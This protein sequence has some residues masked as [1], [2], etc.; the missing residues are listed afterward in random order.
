MKNKTSTAHRLSILLA[1]LFLLSATLVEPMRSHLQSSDDVT[2][3]PAQTFT[4]TNTNNSGAGSLTQAIT[5]ANANPGLDTINFNVPGSGIRFIFVN[6]TLPAITSPV[7]IDGT[8]QPG[9]AGTPLIHLEGMGTGQAL[10]ITAG[11]STIKGLSFT[12]FFAGAANGIVKISGTGNNI[13]TRCSFGVRGD[14]TRPTTA[15]IGILI[16]GS[17][18]NRV[19][20]TTAADRNYFAIGSE[21]NLV[22][23]NGASGNRVTGNW[24][25]TGPNGTRMDSFGRDAIRILNSPSNTIGGSVGTTPGGA[26]TGECNLIDGA[27]NNGIF[28][29][30]ST[31]TGNRII[32]NFVGLFANGT[33]VNQNNL[34]IRIDN[35]PGNTVGGSSAGERN[36]ITGNDGLAGIMVTGAAST[37]TVITGNYIGLFTNGTS[38]P[39]AASVSLDGVLVNAGAANTRI[40]GVMPGERNVVSG[41]R[42]NGIEIAGADTNLVQGNYIGTDASGMARSTT[43]GNGVGM[44]FANN[45]TI[46]GTAGT[47]LGGACTGACNVISG[48]GNDGA[49]DGI[50]VRS[51]N[52]NMIDGNYIGLNA[53]GT[54]AILN[55]RTTSGSI[56]NGNAISLY[57]ANNNVIGRHTGSFG[58]RPGD[59]DPTVPLVNICIQSPVTGNYIMFNDETGAYILENCVRGGG[60]RTGIGTVQL[61]LATLHFKTHMYDPIVAQA[62]YNVVSNRGSGHATGGGF[63]LIVI[64]DT[65]FVPNCTCPNANAG[66]QLI[67]GTVKVGA[68]GDPSSN[69]EFL[70]NFLGLQTNGDPL[71]DK[72]SATKSFLLK[73][74][75]NN[76]I[77]RDFEVNSGTD[78]GVQIQHDEGDSV[79]FNASQQVIPAEPI[80][81]AV[82]AQGDIPPPRLVSVKVYSPKVGVQVVG[83]LIDAIPLR[84]YRIRFIGINVASSGELDTPFFADLGITFEVTTDANGDVTFD[85]YFTGAE[86]DHIMFN[87]SLTA[88][89][90]LI[91]GSLARSGEVLDVLRSTSEISNKIHIPR[92][93]VDFDQ[94]GQ[95]DIAVYRKGD[96]MGAPSY[97]YVLNSGDGTFRAAQF[98]NGEDKV[99]PGDFHAD[100]INDFA[101]FRPSSGSWFFSNI[102]GNPGTHFDAF[103]WGLATDTSLA[104]DFDGDRRADLAVFRSGTWYIR[105]SLTASLSAQQFGLATDKPVP[106]DYNG[107]GRTD[108]AVYREGNW[109]VSVCPAC[110]TLYFNFGLGTDIP[111]PADY[112]GDGITDPSVFRPSTGVRY[113]L[114]SSSGFTAR[115][116]GQNGDKPLYGD[117]DGDGKYDIGVWRPSDGNWYILRSGTGGPYAIHWGQS[118]DIPVSSF[119]ARFHF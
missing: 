114:G 79:I 13:I 31:A 12:S 103:N 71:I 43:V 47:T 4:V 66:I 88:T 36:V 24:F 70:E 60:P 95:T 54:V 21:Q 86:A 15:S 44:F 39:P 72:I 65:P 92:A 80:A 75:G 3:A 94:D 112:D 52:S 91:E 22:I 108:L 45:N 20:G 9:Y 49:S 84:R 53:S 27:G 11:G 56:F 35:A 50:T 96:T 6:A 107:D 59:G 102:S 37:G 30:G 64:S 2:L 68:P 33:S 115:Q 14:S 17:N 26:C 55:G 42:N 46:G 51:S 57:S 67:G 74:S 77:F 69:N 61:D 90:T 106:A 16:D 99:I 87:D 32:G 48:N 81:V 109:Y 98:G 29:N 5:D 40:G 101:V 76:N 110:P 100:R 18:N 85:R 25:G 38:A 118:G 7:V 83:S 117:F 19:G 119:E 63:P 1:S 28:I 93:P 8:S 34:G 23:Q 89:A 97:W 111:T 73:D 10:N 41:L 104:G 113:I 82:G 58:I 78:P 105:Q 62:N 116:W